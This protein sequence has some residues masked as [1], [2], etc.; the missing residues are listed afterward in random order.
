MQGVSGR[1]TKW[2][3]KTK[4]SQKSLRDEVGIGGSIE[5]RAG[6]PGRGLMK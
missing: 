4:G 1:D 3:A 6:R 5:V 2:G